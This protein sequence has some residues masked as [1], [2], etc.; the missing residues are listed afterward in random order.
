[1]ERVGEMRM[2]DESFPGRWIAQRT[3]IDWSV[4]AFNDENYY[5]S[6][7]AIMKA[8]L[9]PESSRQPFGDKFQHRI[10]WI[11]MVWQRSQRLRHKFMAD[12]RKIDR[13][14]CC[15]CLIYG[16][17]P[18]RLLFP[19][20]TLCQ[21]DEPPE[22]RF[23]NRCGLFW[24]LFRFRKLNPAL[25]HKSP[26]DRTQRWNAFLISFFH[27]SLRCRA[28]CEPYDISIREHIK[29]R[30]W[31]TLTL[32]F[33]SMCVD[34]RFPRLFLYSAQENFGGKT[35]ILRDKRNIADKSVTRYAY[36]VL[37]ATKAICW[38]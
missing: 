27:N 25:N 35:R 19:T 15:K 14:N 23:I 4:F 29:S 12:V 22:W 37:C 2:R 7:P 8:H 11:R 31:Q 3:L 1:M 38:C 6:I 16:M 36:F 30:S 13:E 24:E 9:C 28:R 21:W 5:Y 20:F 33:R 34:R 26:E 18:L 32:L 10:A 17:A